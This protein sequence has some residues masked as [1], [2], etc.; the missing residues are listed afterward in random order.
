M[1]ILDLWW[2]HPCWH[3][4]RMRCGISDGNNI[5]DIIEIVAMMKIM[6][7]IKIIKLHVGTWKHWREGEKEKEK[8]NGGSVVL[9]FRVSQQAECRDGILTRPWQI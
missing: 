1:K 4:T 3:V 8:K 9:G 6:K 5:Y 7:M 2:Y